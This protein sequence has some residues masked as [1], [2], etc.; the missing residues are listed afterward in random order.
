MNVTSILPYLFNI[1]LLINFLY[2][3]FIIQIMLYIDEKSG[4]I[5]LRLGNLKNINLIGNVKQNPKEVCV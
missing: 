4:M 3:L 1:Y 2:L 5:H